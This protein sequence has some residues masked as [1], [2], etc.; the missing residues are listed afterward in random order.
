MIELKYLKKGEDSPTARERALS[1]GRDQLRRYL[2][3]SNRMGHLSRH[4]L[5]KAVAVYIGAEDLVW[6]EG[7]P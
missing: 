2:T 3:D 4:P 5:H 6:W 7:E 1:E